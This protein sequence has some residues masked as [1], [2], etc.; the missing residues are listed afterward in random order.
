MKIA[1]YE[2]TT[3]KVP[4][5]EPGPSLDPEAARPIAEESAT[6]TWGVDLGAYELVEESQ[7][8]RPS[9]RTDHTFVYERPDVRIGEGLYR[10]RLVVSGDRFTELTHFVKLPE[11]FGRRFEEMRSANNGIATGASI[12]AAIL[13]VIGGCVIGLFMLL[14][15]RWVLWKQP[16]M[17]GLFVAFLQALVLLNQWPLLWMQYDTAISAS[18]FSMQ[19]LIQALV[20]FLGMG[21]QP[22]IPSWGLMISEGREFMLFDPYLITIPGAALFT[23]VLGIN[24]LGDGLRDV[25]APEGRA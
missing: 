14:R 9:G 22:P 18:T 25:T 19:I 4:E 3:L 15:K 7:E 13:Y 12:A 6:G 20:T 23:L 21:V 16:L 11:A 2:A 10:L 24:L 8:E 17:W 1:S 5:D